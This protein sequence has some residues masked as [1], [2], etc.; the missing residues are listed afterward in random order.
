M[1]CK[2]WK[3]VEAAAVA[4]EEIQ[5]NQQQKRDWRVGVGYIWLLLLLTQ[6]IS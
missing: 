3:A 5:R 1:S 4:G 6:E 2:T